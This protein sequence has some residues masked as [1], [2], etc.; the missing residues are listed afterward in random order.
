MSTASLAGDAV[1][2]AV[3]AVD[4]VSL[5]WI[6]AV[7]VGYAPPWSRGAPTMAARDQR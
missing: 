7:A 4:S 5:T 2:L 6:E 3:Q 1:A